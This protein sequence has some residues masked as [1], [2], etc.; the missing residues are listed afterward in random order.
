MSP[1]PG[2]WV[3]TKENRQA[4]LDSIH[5]AAHLEDAERRAESANLRGELA[6]RWEA[7]LTEAKLL[8]E[9]RNPNASSQEYQNPTP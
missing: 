6:R 1:Y 4:L 2:E 3:I 8:H 7:Q 9:R 5:L